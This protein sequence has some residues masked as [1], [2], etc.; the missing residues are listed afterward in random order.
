MEPAHES[1][2]SWPVLRRIFKEWAGDSAELA[3]VRPLIGGCVNTTL[4]LTAKD[5]QKAVL[6]ICAHRVN[7]MYAHEALQ[8][9]LLRR[10]GV[11]TPQVYVWKTGTLDDPYSYILMEHVEGIDLA[12]AKRTCT[13]EEFDH[14][15]SH[16]AELVLMMHENTADGYGRVR[17]DAPRSDQWSKFFRQVYDPLLHEVNQSGILP[18]KCRKHL[19]KIHDKL[20]RILVNTDQP[21]LVHWDLWATNLLAKPNGHGRWHITAVLD[22]NC[23]YAHAEAELAYLELFHTTTPAFFKRYQQ[24]HKLSAEYHRL[25]K[26]LYQLYSL[27]NHVHLFGGEYLKP[28]AEAVD[29]VSAVV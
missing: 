5:G 3:E 16:L 17:S 2:I 6:K 26:P 20:E 7:R 23:K 8:L 19:H 4:G 28:L 25:R 13:A 22:P 1:D 18:A 11:P 12:R 27:V 9:E 24:R 15:Q 21:R 10:I 29:R 14:L